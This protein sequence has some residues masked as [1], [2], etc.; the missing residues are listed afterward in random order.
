MPAILKHSP[1]SVLVLAPVA[2][3]GVARFMAGL[4]LA[5]LLFGTTVYNSELYD[6][7]DAGWQWGCSALGISHYD[8]NSLQQSNGVGQ[9]MHNA[10]SVPAVLIF[11]VLYVGLCL[12][13]QR[14]LLPQASQRRLVSW[15]YGGAC[16]VVLGLL[17]ASKLG[18]SASLVSLN[19]QLVHFVVSPLPVIILVPLLRW[20]MPISLPA[21][22][23][24]AEA[25]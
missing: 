6:L 10:H 7:L 1:P 16:G 4:L 15:F 20:Y 12:A 24:D 23:T 14:V 8:P 5:G 22:P 18:G 13:L 11:G 19:K 21:H 17:L 3:F 9:L 25:A 2:S